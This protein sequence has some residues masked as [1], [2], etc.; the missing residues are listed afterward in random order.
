M[1]R[2]ITWVETGGN[3][4]PESKDREHEALDVPLEGDEGELEIQRRVDVGRAILDTVIQD[5]K[6]SGA[7]T[8]PVNASVAKAIEVMRKKKVGAV[9]VVSNGRPRK[10][11]GLLT[12]R[13]L[14]NRV[15]SVKGYG[16]LRLDKVM[17]RAPESLRPKD[18]LAYALNKMSVGRFRHIPLV[19]DRNVP[20]GM[21]S[22]RDI[23]DFVVELIPEAVLN[24]PSS[25]ELAEH[26]TVE[27]D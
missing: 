26:K 3:M 13:D 11:V 22:I 10:L 18:S 25:P 4:T 7:V 23:I 5:V 8:L 2:E 21:L 15:L 20:V 17:T 9:M 1:G 24:L 14:V 12:E 16:R 27:G 6:P 19:D